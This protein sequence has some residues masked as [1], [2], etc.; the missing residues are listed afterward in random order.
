MRLRFRFFLLTSTLTFTPSLSAFATTITGP[1]VDGG[2]GYNLVQVQH[3]HTYGDEEGALTPSPTRTTGIVNQSNLYCSLSTTGSPGMCQ[4]KEPDGQIKQVDFSPKGSLNNDT[5]LGG[6]GG[7]VD[8]NPYEYKVVDGK[9]IFSPVTANSPQTLVNNAI[10]AGVK[11]IKA[12]NLIGLPVP[13]DLPTTPNGG[14][15]PNP[16]GKLSSD[17]IEKLEAHAFGL[18]P[19]EQILTCTTQAPPNDS[20]PSFRTNDCWW[21]KNLVLC[22]CTTK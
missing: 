12:R 10:N 18:G 5:Y 8:G 19:S 14:D 22:R 11:E 4:I 9:K 6:M 7:G 16:N 15:N 3:V 1:Y 21:Y 17:E 13:N 20:K 2:A